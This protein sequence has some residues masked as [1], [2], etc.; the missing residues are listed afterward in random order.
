MLDNHTS[1]MFINRR[2]IIVSP[3]PP[4]WNWCPSSPTYQRTLE[5]YLPN[6]GKQLEMLNSKN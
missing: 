2:D 5:N 4:V 1:S 6:V 3:N